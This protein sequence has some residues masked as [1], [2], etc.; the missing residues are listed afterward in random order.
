MLIRE[1]EE[2]VEEGVEKGRRG[3]WYLM[4]RVKR[5]I[6]ILTEIKVAHL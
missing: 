1:E 5:F 2:E 3:K 4:E 6:C